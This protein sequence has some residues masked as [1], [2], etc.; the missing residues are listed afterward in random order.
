MGKKLP[1]SAAGVNDC[2][3]FK[4]SKRFK[5]LR[6]ENNLVRTSGIFAVRK[7]LFREFVSRLVA[8]AFDGLR[9]FLSGRGI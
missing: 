3:A 5:K 6:I 8:H 4:I 2:K 9:A 7:P 1:V